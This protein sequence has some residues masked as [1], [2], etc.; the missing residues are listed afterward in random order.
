MFCNC[1]IY[2]NI[3]DDECGATCPECGRF[4]SARTRRTHAPEPEPQPDA[5][6]VFTQYDLLDERGTVHTPKFDRIFGNREDAVEYARAYRGEDP[7]NIA[8]VLPLH[9]A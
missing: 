2:V 5:W 7:R 3:R 4:V 1:G 8:E 9:R 6:M